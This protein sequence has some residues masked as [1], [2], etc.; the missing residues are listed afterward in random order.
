MRPVNRPFLLNKAELAQSRTPAELSRWVGKVQTELGRKPDSR[1]YARSGALCLKKFYDEILPLAL[2]T[3]KEFG[4]RDD[5]LI[6]PNLD[7]DNFDATIELS[8]SKRIY[9]EITCAKNGRDEALRIE[10]LNKEGHVNA[11][12]PIT[13]VGTRYSQNRAVT[14][15][16]EA[17][18]HA[19]VISEHLEL[20]ERCLIGKSNVRYGRD[21]VLLLVVD[22]YIPFRCEKDIKELTTFM[23]SKLTHVSLDFGRIVVIGISGQLFLRF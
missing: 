20:V 2:F 21:H 17:V 13:V 14:I 1:K 19:D 4:N 3:Y 22:D 11:L 7:N 23:R 18:N 5:V 10:V 6:T 16:D 8:K 12:A 9:V 15:P